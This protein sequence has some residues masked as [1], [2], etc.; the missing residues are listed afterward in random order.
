MKAR[1]I[2]VSFFTLCGL[3]SF[4]QEVIATAGGSVESEDMS[5]SYTIGEPITETFSSAD[6]V[7]IQGMQQPI[8]VKKLSTGLEDIGI[9]AS[10]YPNPTAQLVCIEASIYNG[11]IFKLT[12]SDGR[13][14]QEGTLTEK[15]ELDLNNYAAGNYFITLGNNNA[16]QY[17]IVKK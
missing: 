16:R 2:L 12:S 4:A 11:T 17:Q 9:S 14:L 3:T 6:Y 5:I 7:L 1:V 10:V 8:V 15:V 13:V